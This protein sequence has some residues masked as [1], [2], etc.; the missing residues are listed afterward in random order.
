MQAYCVFFFVS[1]SKCQS[2]L[3]IVAIF[4]DI[5]NTIWKYRNFMWSSRIKFASLCQFLESYFWYSDLALITISL[6]SICYKLD[7]GNLTRRIKCTG[8]IL[9]PYLLVAFIIQAWW[10][11]LDLHF[12]TE[13]TFTSNLFLIIFPPLKSMPLWATWTLKPSL[14]KTNISTSH[15]LCLDCLF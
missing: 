1:Y 13:K 11:K 10:K 8:H 7:R 9:A 14:T 15:G 6:I 4:Q 3:R 12:S 5:T 2:N